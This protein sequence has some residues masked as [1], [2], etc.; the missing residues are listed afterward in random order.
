[1][2]IIIL[3][4]ISG[5]SEKNRESR[6]KTETVKSEANVNLTEIQ[7]KDYDK[8]EENTGE[9]NSVS[10]LELYK[11]EVSESVGWGEHFETVL[12]DNLIF[13]QHFYTIEDGAFQYGYYLQVYNTI[14]GQKQENYLDDHSLADSVKNIYSDENMILSRLKSG[15]LSV[16]GLDA[17]D[18]KIYILWVL[19]DEEFNRENYFVSVMNYDGQILSSNTIAEGLWERQNEG[20]RRSG[21]SIGISRRNGN[22]SIVRM[23]GTH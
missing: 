9:E 16:I 14:T 12:Q 1:M 15:R 21:Y 22:S 17:K 6:E 13:L 2:S 7:W 20:R 3:C 5:C 18:D 19:S 11:R 23:L 4:Y 10:Y 8:I